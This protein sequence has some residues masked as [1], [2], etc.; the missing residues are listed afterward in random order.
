MIAL[1]GVSLFFAGCPTDSDSPPPPTP[2]AARTTTVTPSDGDNTLAVT[3][4]GGSLAS[5]LKAYILSA[6]GT[7]VVITK[8]ASLTDHTEYANVTVSGLVIT[9]S[10]LTDADSTGGA[11][12]LNTAGVSVTLAADAQAAQVT[13]IAAAAATITDVTD[14]SVTP[15][16]SDTIATITATGGSFASGLKVYIKNDGSEITITKA[17]TLSG[18]T[19]YSGSVV[20]A[21]LEIVISGLTGAGDTGN[22]TTLDSDAAVTVTLAIDAQTTQV[23]SIAPVFSQ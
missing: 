23:T 5:G 13:S 14:S 20:A 4:A 22:A 1:L 10:G 6:D 15:S 19:E 9:L 11:D 7:A 18:F 3:A 17:A 12:T 2:I 16:A 8:A 21:G